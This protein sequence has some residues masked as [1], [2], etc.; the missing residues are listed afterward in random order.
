MHLDRFLGLP[1]PALPEIK[2]QISRRL[3]A[4]RRIL[5]VALVDDPLRFRPYRR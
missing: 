1:V 3:I 5:L 2:Q 4:L